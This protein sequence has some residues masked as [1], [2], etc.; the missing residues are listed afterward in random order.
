MRLLLDTHALLWGMFDPEQ[1]PEA[2]RAEIL[3]PEHDVM[4]SVASL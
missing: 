1:I 4:V 2:V 3:D